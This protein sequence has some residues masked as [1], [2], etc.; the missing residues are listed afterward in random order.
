MFTAIILTGILDFDVKR[1]YFLKEIR[2]FDDRFVFI[3][4]ILS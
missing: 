4:Y 1:K 2:K 3:M